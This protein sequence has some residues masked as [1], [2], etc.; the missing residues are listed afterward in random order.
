M[1]VLVLGA[2]GA[3]GR[4]LLEQLLGRGQQVRALVRSLDAMPKAICHHPGLTLV[5][6]NILELRSDELL[7]LVAGCTSVASC[8][9]H[10]L[11]LRGIFGPPWSLVTAATQRIC[12]AVVASQP[13]QPVKF[14]L[15]NTAANADAHQGETVSVAQRL[16]V[17][18]I[19]LLVPPHS[20][21]ENAAEYLRRQASRQAGLPWV[22]VRPDALINE[23]EVSGYKVLASPSRSAI[24][25]AGKTSRINVAHFMADLLTIDE[26]WQRWQGQMP[27]IYNEAFAH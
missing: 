7:T 8:L 13:S 12:Q 23:A 14:V 27:V 9:G 15:M 6:G 21:N 5:Q 17:G 24:F 10:N 26:T 1:T 4:L 3:T 20:D 19:R 16:V 2:S 18:L 25:N 22:A 11:T